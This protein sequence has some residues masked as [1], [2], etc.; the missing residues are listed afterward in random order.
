[1]SR[2]VAQASGILRQSGGRMTTQRRLILETLD[3]M[4]GHPT[5]DQICRTVRTQDA[6]INPSTIYRTLGWLAE[7]GLVDARHLAPGRSSGRREQFDPS[8][9]A[10][11]HHFVCTGCGT[12]VEFAS[13]Q[14]E[15]A[16]QEFSH[17]QGVTVERASLTLYG[18][19]A[20]CQNAKE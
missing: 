2:L 5:A 6:S 1:V 12:V 13:P 15:L 19:C 11:H 14:I 9:P 8:V 17:A 10:E 7:A 3:E 4:G 20:V 18:L 16:K